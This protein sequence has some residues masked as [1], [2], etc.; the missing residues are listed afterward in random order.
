MKLALYILIVIAALTIII[1]IIS[2]LKR[3][4]M[5]RR[6]K[7]ASGGKLLKK[8]GFFAS[9]FKQNG[10]LDYLIEKDGKKYA[11]SVV[12][13]AHKRV[14]Y[15]FADETL[16]EIV[17]RKIFIMIGNMR[18]AN[19][20]K[21]DLR[22]VV[23]RRHMDFSSLILCEGEKWVIAYPAPIELTKVSGNGITILGNGDRLFGD[24]RV[25]GLKHFTDNVLG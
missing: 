22:W 12:G 6:L 13:S 14:K 24:I 19:N 10:S 18:T 9:F 7:K 1:Y 4:S 15:H 23:A 17:R 2:M 21:A 11:V 16:M 3:L 8:R 20:G 25:C 5:I